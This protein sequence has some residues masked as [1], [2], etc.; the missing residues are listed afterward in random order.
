[1]TGRHFDFFEPDPDM[2][3]DAGSGVLTM[4]ALEQIGPRHERFVE[5]L[6]QKKPQVCVNMEPL[7]ELYE[8]DNLVDYLAMRYH[9]KRG[10]LDGFLTSLRNLAAAGRIEILDVR[11]FFFGSIYHEAYSYV[12]WRPL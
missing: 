2:K 3:L 9:R 11:R 6:L 10:Y 1:V 7:L 5:F 8:D 12:A 4:C